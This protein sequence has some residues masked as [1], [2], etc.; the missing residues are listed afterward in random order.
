MYVGTLEDRGLPVAAQRMSVG[1][2][3]GMG[4]RVVHR[5]LRTSHSPFLS[6]PDAV[7]ALI[8]EALDYFRTQ[9]P[10]M[11]LARVDKATVPEVRL[12]QPTSW[13][14]FG[15]PLGLGRVMG[16]GVAGF[17]WI[18]KAFRSVRGN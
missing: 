16:W 10:S 12:W 9:D 15:L 1:M 14:R 8:L 3:R 17:L 4:A 11:P 18:R 2:A 5:E 7:V 13:F 6:Q